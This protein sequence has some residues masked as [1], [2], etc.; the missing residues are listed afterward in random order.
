MRIQSLLEKCKKNQR[1]IIAADNE[2]ALIKEKE[3][4]R[5]NI[6]GL[7]RRR[8]LTNAQKLLIKE[9]FKP[10]TRDVQAKVRFPLLQNG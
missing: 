8:K 10:W 5:K 2:E 3:L 6:N 7:I 4:V 9:E 1:G